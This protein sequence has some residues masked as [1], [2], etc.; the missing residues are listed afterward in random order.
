MVALRFYIDSLH[1]LVRSRTGWINRFSPWLH[2]RPTTASFSV[3]PF[4][5]VASLQAVNGATPPRTYRTG[6][7]PPP[8]R[9]CLPAVRPLRPHLTQSLPFPLHFSFQKLNSKKFHPASLPFSH[10][11][12]GLP[13]I[14][15]ACA[16]PGGG[17][18]EGGENRTEQQRKRPRTTSRDFL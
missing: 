3:Q 8:L 9:L 14:T 1:V 2:S 15:S 17:H 7:P 11:H 16:A 10:A 6:A 13:K 12:A 18:G 4:N 5:P